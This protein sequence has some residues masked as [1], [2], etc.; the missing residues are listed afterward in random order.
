MRYGYLQ[1]AAAAALLATALAYP[2]TAAADLRAG[3]AAYRAGDYKKAFDEFSE[4]AKGGDARAQFNLGVMYMTGRGVA[5]DVAVSL[6]WHRKAAEQKLPAA[7]H[8]MG[9][10]YY[11]G[12]GVEKDY[13]E[14]LR[15]FRLAAAQGF[16]NSQFNIA[17][18]YFNEQGLVRND[19]EI[20]KWVSLAAGQDFVPALLRLAEMYE[21]GIIFTRN[22]REAMAWY[23]RAAAR[24][25]ARAAAALAR[26]ERARS[27]LP[28]EKP[29]EAG[30]PDAPTVAGP[31]GTET[32]TVT[33]DPAAP[34]M[35]RP[36]AKVPPTSKP[37]EAAPAPPSL[38]VAP[39][40]HTPSAEAKPAE[41]AQPSPGMGGT[42]AAPPLPIA[43]PP[44]APKPDT[45]VKDTHSPAAEP[46]TA[47][48]AMAERA[49]KPGEWRVQFASFRNIADAV[50]AW[51]HLKDRAGPALA[52]VEPIVAPADL[53][54]RG[55]YHRLQAGP[56]SDG[57]TARE[58]CAKVQAAIPGQACLAVRT[59]PQ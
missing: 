58:L 24:G 27:G 17:V 35:P 37:V 30:V 54:T 49:G 12:N 47:A 32:G 4:L 51:Q 38:S 10:F 59:A 31:H 26:L 3:V 43:T 9:V 21:K 19:L 28:P 48:P 16:A 53:G 13:G 50:N 42:I 2:V 18:M 7:Q 22:D 14:A 23:A 8:G 36:A 15:W 11:Q 29:A 25:D 33:E 1:K 40:A 20:V 5:R 46:E 6:E 41:P 45:P 55:I 39:P 52:G 34:P 57:D 56:L 44:A